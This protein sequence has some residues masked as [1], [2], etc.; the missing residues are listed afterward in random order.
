MCAYVADGGHTHTGII[1]Y[2]YISHCFILFINFTTDKMY[3][4]SLI[5]LFTMLNMFGHVFAS[6][7]LWMLACVSQLLRSVY[8]SVCYE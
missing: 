7:F 4:F 8:D 5:R 6:T 1:Q 3:L 2:V